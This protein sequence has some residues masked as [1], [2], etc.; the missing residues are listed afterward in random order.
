MVLRRT[1]IPLCFLVLIAGQALANDAERLFDDGIVAMEAGQYDKACPMLERS[2]ALEPKAGGLVALADCNARWGRF[3]TAVA[4]FKSYL[5]IVSRM[6]PAERRRHMAR[7]AIARDY[8][9]RLEHQVPELILILPENA[10]DGATAMLD[11]VLL[12]TT[13]YGLPRPMDPGVHVIVTRVPG[14]SDHTV[15]FTLE[16]GQKKRMELAFASAEQSLLGPPAPAVPNPDR[17]RAPSIRSEYVWTAGAVGAVGILAGTVTGVMVFSKKSTMENNC[18]GYACNKEGAEAARN[19][20]QL[21]TASNV[22]W[23]I[24]VVGAATALALHL[25]REGQKH[26]SNPLAPALDIGTDRVWLGARADW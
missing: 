21:A 7:E 3:A 13:V 5:D 22:C 14:G 15:R 23:S 2:H 17:G 16:P 25:V 18:E 6:P 9:A 8:V 24:G 4:G 20:Q 19:A 1:L 11:D 26:D 12:S 10:P